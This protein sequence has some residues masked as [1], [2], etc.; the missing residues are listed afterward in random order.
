MEPSV[1]SHRVVLINK[2]AYGL[3]IPGFRRYLFQWGQPKEGDILLLEDPLTDVLTIKRCTQTTPFGLYVQG[4]NLLFSVD[5][6]LY[7]SISMDQVWGKMILT[8]PG[9]WK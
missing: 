3:R 5:S 9:R 6:R 7:G 2:L 8:I 1:S 4:D